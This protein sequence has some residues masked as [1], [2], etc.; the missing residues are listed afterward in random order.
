[1]WYFWLTRK[2]W[3][4]SANVLP[5]E[6]TTLLYPWYVPTVFVFP[7]QTSGNCL[8]GKWF[9]TLKGFISSNW[10]NCFCLLQSDLHISFWIKQSNVDDWKVLSF[11]LF[12]LY[13]CIYLCTSYDFQE[14]TVVKKVLITSAFIDITVFVL[15][16]ILDLLHFQHSVNRISHCRKIRTG[17]FLVSFFFFFF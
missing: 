9:P 5:A 1:M 2:L 14:E 16:S 4:Y 17:N 3:Q 12:S 11:R 8:V 6:E 10:N 15:N 13:H 7:W